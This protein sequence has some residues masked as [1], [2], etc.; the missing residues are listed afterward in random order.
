M[1]ADAAGRVR[2]FPDG[3]GAPSSPPAANNLLNESALG[4]RVSGERRLG[5]RRAYWGCLR[6]AVRRSAKRSCCHGTVGCSFA[7]VSKG[8]TALPEPYNP[9]C[10][11]LISA[12]RDEPPS[13]FS[14]P[15]SENVECGDS[16]SSIFPTHE[17]REVNT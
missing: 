16:S 14:F 2:C 1:P 8:A 9:P 15:L 6:L 4:S 7:A 13:V 11:A 17:R 3:A 10:L 12:A 5:D